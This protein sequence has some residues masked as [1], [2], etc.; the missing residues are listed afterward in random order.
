MVSVS[1]LSAW[2]W[3]LKDFQPSTLDGSDQILT[4][5]GTLIW[6]TPHMF[7]DTAHTDYWKL[8]MSINAE[9]NYE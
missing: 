7:Y 5:D 4:Q 3:T 6:V 8:E 2:L 1:L 9:N